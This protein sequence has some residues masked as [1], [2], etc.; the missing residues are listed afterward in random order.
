[1]SSTLSYVPLSSSV[2]PSF[3]SKLTELKL[4][5]YKLNEVEQHIW[6]YSELI[7]NPNC[8]LSLVEID[9]TSFNTCAY[10]QNMNL[11]FH[12][13]LINTNTIE[14]F[15]E[16]DKTQL[17]NDFGVQLQEKL[18]NGEAL[19]NPSV[20]NCFILLSF[21][22]IKKFH[23]YY[24]FAFPVPKGV[25]IINITTHKIISEFNND[26]LQKFLA[27][28]KNLDNTQNGY[29]A[30]FLK[31]NEIE[32]NTLE[33]TYD[34]L[35]STDS[36][37]YFGFYNTAKGSKVGTQLRNF[38]LH[39][40]HYCPFLENKEVKFVA[41]TLSRG[42]SEI[43]LKDS[44]IHV[45]KLPKL[46]P[47]VYSSWVG[48]EKNERDKLGPR[49]AN[50]R[51][52]LD[53][54]V[55][56]ENSVDLNLKLMKWNLLPSIDLEKLKKTKCLLFGA[57]TLGCSVARTLLG[58]GIRNVTFVDN[59]TVSFSNPVRQS[60]F[61]YQ[62]SVEAKP[63]AQAAADGLKLIFP[64][65]NSKGY[66]MNIP[67]PGHTVGQSFIEQTTAD[68]RKLIELIEEH[69]VMFLLMDSRE[70]RWLPTLLGANQ[71]KL[72][73]NAALGFDSYLI[74]RHG[75]HNEITNKSL[76]PHPE[77]FK[78]I[79]G[80]NLGCYFCNDVTAPGDSMKHRT[81]DQQCTV[82]RPGVSQIAG[83]LAAEL[84]VSL[85]QHTDGVSAPAFYTSCNQN[86]N[87][88][89]MENLNPSILGIV[90]HSIRGFLSSF[91]QFLPATEK[92]KNCVACSDL[93]I[94]EYRQKGI[95]FLFKVFGS[96]K[97]LED[98]ALLTEMYK[99]MEMEEILEFSDGED[100]G[101][102]SVG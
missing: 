96:S 102:S 36:E 19:R 38:V 80:N 73:V 2:N 26:L 49:F 99:E 50:M 72:V 92:Y 1:M 58:W 57:G 34:K 5:I 20:L 76:L 41:I 47:N 22:D 81:L 78:C 31:N 54:S 60:L 42:K 15:R 52:S 21:A 90:P 3:W 69:D 35:P 65:V 70:S 9:S 12:G 85:L 98:V 14:R 8:P 30:L 45:L 7:N 64:G 32:L 29:F 11:L 39:I 88:L 101:G 40:L 23:Y 87:N 61:T 28:F 17:I 27:S 93:I 56:A 95:E 67:M 10:G 75:I 94:N 79:L 77:G 33:F 6:G 100:V 46:D 83:A 91:E 84:A 62:D 82:T 24:W 86:S 16:Y 4:D 97:H 44:M 25:N 51:T 43:H 71:K 13:K 59:A 18:K 53:P 68:V 74:M 63:K 48:W 55:I 89:N 66:H 37:I